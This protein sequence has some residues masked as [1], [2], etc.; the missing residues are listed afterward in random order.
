MKKLRFPFLFLAVLLFAAQGYADS[1]GIG[2]GL[3]TGYGVTTY[4]EETTALGTDDSSRA[5]LDTILFGA[6]GEYSFKKYR[7]IFAA[8][9][10]DWTYAFEDVETF[11]RRGNVSF[12]ETRDLSIWSQFY[13]LRIG[14]KNNPGN[15]YYRVYASGGWDGIHFR[16]KNVKVN[17]VST[18]ADAVTEDFNLW[19]VG[20]GIGLG[21]KLGKWALDG[22]YAHGYYFDGEVRNSSRSGLVF[23]TNGTCIDA[24]AGIAYEISDVMH[25]YLG[26]SF[27]E[28]ELDE[29][30]VQVYESTLES[31]VFPESRTRIIAGIINLTYSF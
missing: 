7:N 26:G 29:G 20:G 15:L 3:H 31:V 28:V 13:D 5:D 27:T 12:D 4:E 23:D 11:K 19:R 9:V 22:R 10:A 6:S 14:F 1:M 2:F 8:A 17:G 30:E 21:Y 25:F 24:G 18:S 16:R